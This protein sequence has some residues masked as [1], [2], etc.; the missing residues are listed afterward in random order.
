M[1]PIVRKDYGSR[2]FYFNLKS[3]VI[4]LF[5]MFGINF[6]TKMVANMKRM[7]VFVA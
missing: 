5:F 1:T 6:G 4:P 2:F 7:L 3:Y